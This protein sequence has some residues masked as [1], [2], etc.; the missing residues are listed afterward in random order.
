VTLEFGADGRYSIRTCDDR[1]VH[2]D[3]TLVSTPGPE[4]SFAVELKSV[5]P[6]TAGLALR[7]Q[8]GRYLAGVGRDA[9]VQ[10]RNSAAGKDELF[11]VEESHP[12]VIITAHNGKMVSIKQ[13]KQHASVEL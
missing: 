11:A 10:A 9:V 2:R 6:G 7:D 12:Q 4:T 13:G 3:G 1:Y 8:N 5:A